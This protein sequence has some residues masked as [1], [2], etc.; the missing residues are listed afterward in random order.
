MVW[1]VG[2]YTQLE[3]LNS[4]VKLNAF[5][6][7]SCLTWLN[8]YLLITKACNDIYIIHSRYC[9]DKS[10]YMVYWESVICW[11]RL[12]LHFYHKMLIV[13]KI[14]AAYSSLVYQNLGVV[15]LDVHWLNAICKW[16]LITITSNCSY[17]L[18]C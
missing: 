4:N 9:C 14:V 11:F 16:T 12:S 3:L 8:G 10:R 18:E 15:L 13:K 1:Q 17:S 6:S 2:V 5:A 7:F